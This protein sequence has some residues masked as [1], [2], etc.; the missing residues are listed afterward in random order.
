[1]LS[2]ESFEGGFLHFCNELYMIWKDLKLVLFFQFSHFQVGK[3]GKTN[4]ALFS[5]LLKA[6]SYIEA[7]SLKEGEPHKM[8]KGKHRTLTRILRVSCK[9]I[10]S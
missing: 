6:L 10:S 1:M 8:E 9:F 4:Q 3:H 7:D 2:L 5:N